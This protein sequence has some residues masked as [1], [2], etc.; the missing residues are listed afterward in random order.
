MAAS[1]LTLAG[2]FLRGSRTWEGHTTVAATLGGAAL[3]WPEQALWYRQCV[4]IRE[5]EGTLRLWLRPLILQ[6]E[7]VLMIVSDFFFF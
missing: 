3:P 4:T 1:E 7:R 2:N 6:M 5:V